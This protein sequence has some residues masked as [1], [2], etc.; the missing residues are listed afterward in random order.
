MDETAV[1]AAPGNE[2]LRTDLAASYYG[3][4]FVLG[5]LGDSKEA[6]SYYR[7]ALPIREALLTRDPQDARK[8]M[9]LANNYQEIAKLL[10]ANGE[11]EAAQE[12]YRKVLGLR[13]GLLSTDAE[14]ADNRT[15]LARA[16]SEMGNIAMRREMPH[17]EQLMECIALKQKSLDLYQQMKDRLSGSVANEAKKVQE[18]VAGCRAELGK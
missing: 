16:Y 11:L 3:L 13:E 9:R 2:Q 5:E 4:G 14:G 7:K 18:E 1:Q 12:G 8:K 6:L 10:T 17:R 15:E